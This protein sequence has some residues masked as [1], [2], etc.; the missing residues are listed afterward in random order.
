[1]HCTEQSWLLFPSG[2][3]NAMKSS[4]NAT[5]IGPCI[6]TGQAVDYV[7]FPDRF[8]GFLTKNPRF[9]VDSIKFPAEIT[10]INLPVSPRLKSNL[11]HR[12]GLVQISVWI[13]VHFVISTQFGIPHYGWS[14]SW[15]IPLTTCYSQQQ[16]PRKNFRIPMTSINE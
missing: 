14:S 6:L 10:Q 7:Q 4:Q 8:L 11:T 1:M 15:H 12:R 16:A 2:F 3:Q 13:H 9:G 5:E